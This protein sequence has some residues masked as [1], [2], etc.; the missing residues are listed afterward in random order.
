MPIGSWR[1]RVEAIHLV[2]EQPDQLGTYWARGPIRSSKLPV[3]RTKRHLAPSTW[4][5]HS[6]LWAGTMRRTG[7]QN[8]QDVNQYSRPCNAQSKP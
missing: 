1:V 2:G 7:V 5:A 6:G 8:I 3:P 4:I